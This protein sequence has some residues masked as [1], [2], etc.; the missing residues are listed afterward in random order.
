MKEIFP[1][2]QMKFRKDINGLRAWAVLAVVLFHFKLLNVTGGFIGVD[3][4][5]VIS[6]FFMTGIIVDK[7]ASESFSLSDFYLARARR[8][9]PA[10]V[11]LVTVLLIFGYFCLPSFLYEALGKEIRYAL[12]FLSNVLYWSSSG[13][14]DTASQEK[15]LLHT[16]SLSVEWQFYIFFPIY[17][18]IAWKYY[19]KRFSSTC[20]LQTMFLI[21]LS[22]PLVIT[23]AISVFLSSGKAAFS[24]Y[25]PFTRIWELLAG[26]LVYLLQKR[27]SISPF[28]SKM[29]FAIGGMA[30]IGSCLFFSEKFSWPGGWA[31]IPVLASMLLIFSQRNTVFTDTR[32]AQWLGDRSYSLYLYH[33]PFVAALYYSGY[34]TSIRWTVIS[35]IGSLTLAHLSY[36]L[37]ENPI[38]STFK[39]IKNTRMKFVWISCILVFG[40]IGPIAIKSEMINID[41]G[42]LLGVIRQVTGILNE[43]NNRKFGTGE[44]ITID[45]DNNITAPLYGTEDIGAIIIGDSHS[46][47]VVTA[48]GEAA[49]KHGRGV[50]YLGRGGCPSID[51]V[52]KTDADYN[53]RERYETIFQQVQMQAPDIPVVMVNRTSFYNMGG[54]EVRFLDE[55]QGVISKRVF[56]N[57]VEWFQKEYQEH[58]IKTLCN[59]AKSRV[60]Y[61]MNP[62]PEMGVDVPQTVAKKH[63]RGDSEEVY[64]LKKAYYKRHKVVLEAQAQAEQQCGI[65]ILDPLPYLCDEE[66]CY[67]SQKG[68]PLYF[69]DDHLSE[70]GNKLLTPMFEEIFSDKREET[71]VFSPPPNMAR[72]FIE[73]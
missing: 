52:E 72:N 5:F 50:I 68:K 54:N 25:L 60:V 2:V 4:F 34:E 66:K 31:I 21:A 41:D 59:L 58:L 35:I 1:L 42:R 64:I 26:G 29:S 65:K 38:R 40:L 7:I 53:C 56:S 30:L 22:I 51:G 67:G 24:F 18:L 39:N 20:N 47:A 73:K 12:P 57:K 61:I 71:P 43:K 48:L 10:L 27:F 6:G 15:W 14:F 8:I 62:I 55:P 23:L 36:L 46:S 11:G 32:M 45:E 69:D 19:Q 63:F 70:Y 16:W 13:Y 3:I 49:K 37:I 17:L 9:I 28:M 44:Y 33:W